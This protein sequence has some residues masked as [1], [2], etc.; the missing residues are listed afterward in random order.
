MKKRYSLA[1]VLALVFSTLALSCCAMLAVFLGLLNRMPESSDD[2]YG[3]SEI[4]DVISE[5][6]IGEADEELLITEAKRAM[7]YALDDNWSYYMT[8]EEYEQHQQSMNNTYQGIGV[9]VLINEEYG[10][11]EVTGVYSNSGAQAAGI[12]IGDIITAID[13]VSIAGYSLIDVRSALSRPIDD[14]ALLT[15]RRASGLYEDIEVIYSVI[16]EDPVSFE[17]IDGNIG[18]VYLRNFEGESANSFIH[19]VEELI[20]QG[21]AAFIFDVRSNG[22]GRVGEVT[23]ILD[24]LLPE[25][26]IF[27]TVDETGN[28]YV[29]KSDADFIDLPAVVLVNSHSYSG[30]EYFTAALSEYEYAI[31][32]GEQTTGKNRMQT[33][34]G[35]DEGDAIHISTG[36]YLTPNRVS[37]F[38]TGGYTPDYEVELTEDELI[39]HYNGELSIDDDAQLQKALELLGGTT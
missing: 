19:A 37:L 1:F 13:G 4:L 20:S 29:T 17:M 31:T 21:A 16:F 14:S 22:G 32:V 18:Y 36:M 11:I 2:D 33:T 12:I 5:R 3:F 15:V 27:I 28:E 39:A 8:A 25:G 38:D 23:A 30:A 9:S 10:G 35:L 6:F 24:F 7:V 34:I 26:D